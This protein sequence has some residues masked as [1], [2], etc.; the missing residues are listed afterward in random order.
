MTRHICGAKK[1]KKVEV[2][3]LIS[4][5]T[6]SFQLHVVGMSENLSCRIES[7]IKKKIAENYLFFQNNTSTL[8]EYKYE[9]GKWNV[10][11]Q[12]NISLLILKEPYLL[13]W[14]SL[15]PKK[16]LVSLYLLDLSR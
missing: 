15:V 4:F 1:L 6:H 2:N 14:R 5:F 9:M 7:D 12:I 16:F 8:S 13:H 10:F 3:S 11:L